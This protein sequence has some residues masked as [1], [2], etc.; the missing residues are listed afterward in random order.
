MLGYVDGN[1]LSWSRL[2]ADSLGDK[3]ASTQVDL[4]RR[5]LRASVAQGADALNRKP[6]SDRLPW[7]L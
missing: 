1:D 5:Q 6:L 7:A 3:R 4:P 2:S